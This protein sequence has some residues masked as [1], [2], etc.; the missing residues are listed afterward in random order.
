MKVYTG[1]FANV[2]KYNSAGLVT[3]SIARY[4]RYYTG[5]SMIELAP[6]GNMIHMDEPIFTPTYERLVL[7]KLDVNN[8]L[9]RI[10]E[11]SKGRDA[12]LLCF[13]KSTDFCHRQLVA[14]WITE[15]SGV[16]VEEFETKKPNKGIQLGLYN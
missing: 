14:K 15:K 1:N 7:G 13:E 6:A 11:I 5:A 16:K 2:K 4:P 10:K 3:I 12:I 8:I 9:N